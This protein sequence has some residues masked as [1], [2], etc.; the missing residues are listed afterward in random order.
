MSI[1]ACNGNVPGE[2][3]TCGCAIGR[4]HTAEQH[5]SIL[6]RSQNMLAPPVGSEWVEWPIE[7]RYVPNEGQLKDLWIDRYKAEDGRVRVVERDEAGRGFDSYIASV[8]R[9]ARQEGYE[10]GLAMNVGSPN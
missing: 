8:E 1:H 7:D 9:R 2:N 6:H 3:H 4:D 5:D 10:A